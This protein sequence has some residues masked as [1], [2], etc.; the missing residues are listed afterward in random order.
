MQIPLRAGTQWKGK[1]GKQWDV[2]KMQR[3]VYV[4]HYLWRGT[5]D[6][7]QSYHSFALLIVIANFLL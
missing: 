7:V 3:S 4:V 5:W 2:R 6:Q 1:G